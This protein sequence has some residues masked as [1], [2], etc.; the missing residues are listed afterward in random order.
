M[1]NWNSHSGRV[2]TMLH[3]DIDTD[4]LLPKQFMK[5]IDKK[6][7]KNY[8]FFDQRYLDKDGL[9]ENPNFILNLPMFKK[10]SILIVGKNFGCGSS[11]EHAPWALVDYGFRVI[12]AESFA[13]IF[14]INAV[15]NRIL[16]VVKSKS[17]IK[18]I[19]KNLDDKDPTL[20]INLN[21]Q[22]IN[23]KNKVWKFDLDESEKTKIISGKD[24]INST[25][26]HISQIN[27]YSEKYFIKYPFNFLSYSQI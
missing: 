9:I 26:E 27:E 23:L 4:Q 5:V 21:T 14:K 3:D 7:F 1:E 13:D 20:T 22:T 16:L 18:E 12:I 6:N 19:V 2:C 10:S 11:R 17:E 8:L 15:K 25:L 24:E